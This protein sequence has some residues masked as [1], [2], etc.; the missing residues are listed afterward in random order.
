M[1]VPPALSPVRAIA[2]AE[3]RTTFAL[4]VRYYLSQESRQLPSRYLYDSLGSSLFEA[5]C[6]LPWYAV[7]RS[8]TRLLAAHRDEIFSTAGALT[9]IVELGCGNGEKLATLLAGQRSSRQL[10][11]HLVDISETALAR[12]V[13]RL[14]DAE[15]TRIHAHETTYELGLTRLGSA[16]NVGGQSLVLFLGSNIGTRNFCDASAPLFG[17]AI[18]FSS[19]P[20]W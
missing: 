3:A 8:E 16:Q 7:T 4:D 1:N 11:L 14:N 18:S 5:I 17:R 13:S 9:Q 12:S 20:T 2:D 6:S 19:A 10:D 15:G